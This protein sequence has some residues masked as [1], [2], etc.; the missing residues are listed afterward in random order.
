MLR[1]PATFALLIALAV[2]ACAGVT[3]YLKNGRKIVADEAVETRDSV[4]YTIE[5][6]QY[7]IPKSL[8]DRIES[9]EAKPLSGDAVRPATEAGAIAPELSPAPGG[10]L[11]A[12][13][14][15]LTRVVRA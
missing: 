4:Q 14:A 15:L 9:S 10:S 5:D 8:V 3:I 6:G 11:P 7:A 12:A 13:D 2:P 1:V